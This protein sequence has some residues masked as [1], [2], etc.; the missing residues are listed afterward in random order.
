MKSE[1][2]HRKSEEIKGIPK[3]IHRKSKEMHRKSKKINRKSKKMHSLNH[4]AVIT[5]ASSGIGKCILDVSF[6]ILLG[7]FPSLCFM[8]ASSSYSSHS[9]SSSS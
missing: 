7:K 5:G 6:V 9:S 2:I 3:E 4:L 1:E 8:Y